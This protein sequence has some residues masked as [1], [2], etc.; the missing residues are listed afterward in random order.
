[1]STT[2]WYCLS[3]QVVEGS[4]SPEEAG[5]RRYQVG[6]Q[7][8]LLATEGVLGSFQRRLHFTSWLFHSCVVFKESNTSSPFTL[9]LS[10]ALVT[11]L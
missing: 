2:R 8:A 7:T 1:M 6:K 11:C 10:L 5:P 3:A 9:H 4:L